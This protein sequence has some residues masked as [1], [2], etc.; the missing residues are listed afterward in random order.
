M[1][2]L[3]YLKSIRCAKTVGFLFEGLDYLVALKGSAEIEHPFL[4]VEGDDR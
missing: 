1:T 3:I 4:A 2:S